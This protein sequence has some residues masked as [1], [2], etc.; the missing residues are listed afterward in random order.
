VTRRTI[1]I[2]TDEPGETTL[3]PV[4]FVH[5]LFVV[6]PFQ[7]LAGEIDAGGF[8]PLTELIQEAVGDELEAL[9]D[10]LVVDL[11]L[12]LDLFGGLE[13]RGESSL[14]LAETHVMEPRG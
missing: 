11:A 3:A 4:Q 14:E 1:G 8:A 9:L 6:D 13:L 7:Q 12:A 10:Q 2:E 5:D